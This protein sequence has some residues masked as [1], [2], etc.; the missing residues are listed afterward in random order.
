[1]H[2]PVRKAQHPSCRIPLKLSV[3][4]LLLDLI[5]SELRI[6]E[7]VTSRDSTSSIYRPISSILSWL[8]LSQ[9]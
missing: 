3:S 4:Q 7:A 1:M 6:S 5:L 8:P 9:Y 2:D